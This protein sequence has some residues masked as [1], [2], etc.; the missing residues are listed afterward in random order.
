M[1]PPPHETGTGRPDR[2]GRPLR[3]GVCVALALLFLGLGYSTLYRAAA[4]GGVER[5]DFT[6]YHAAGVAVLD[7]TNI[8]QAQN[9]RG[10]YYMYLPIFAVLMVPLAMLPKVAAAGVFYLL[11]V[12]A[13]LHL[14][15]LSAKLAGSSRPFWV[16]FATLALT[17]WPWMSGLTRG[18][19]SVILSWLVV[20]SVASFLK[21]GRLGRWGGAFALALATLIRV[22][23]GLLGLWLVLGRRWSAVFACVVAGLTLLLIIPS[24][25]FG[26]RGNLDLVGQ[27]VRTV[28]LPTDNA[29]A[30]DN[31]RYG[32]MLDPRIDKNQ[33]VQATLIRWLAPDEE[34]GGADRR[35]KLARRLATGVNAGLVLAT[36]AAAFIAGRRRPGHVPAAVV[37]AAAFCVLCLLVP[38][39][40]WVHNYSLMMLPLAVAVSRTWDGST[41]LRIALLL[42]LAGVV[43]CFT[44][45][46]YRGGGF[47]IGAL[48][49]WVVL[50][51]DLLTP[52]PARVSA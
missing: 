5:S 44:D 36:L 33:S 49:V 43:A 21:N 28:A 11:S 45:A 42:W 37:Q 9:V 15:W 29:A 6:V 22:F 7:G 17:A 31:V 13:L 51:L 1:H 52:P 35:E 2:A 3:I 30:E 16:A 50:V 4:L 18:Q 46:G 24:L 41:P 25:L 10:W 27:W 26:P 48:G 38:P 8:Y 39:V 23:P 47:A 20:V 12:A 14:A 32:Q 34:R 19:A 40:S